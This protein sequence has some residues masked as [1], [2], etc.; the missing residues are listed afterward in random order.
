MLEKIRYFL[1]GARD[2]WRA[3]QSGPIQDELRRLKQEA[4][5]RGEQ[6]T[7]KRIWCLEQ[8]LKAQDEFTDAFKQMKAGAYYDGWCALER[9]EL[10]LHFLSPHLVEED[11]EYGL[12]FINRHIIQYQ[13]LFPYRHFLSPEIL[14]LEKVCT[15][16]N[17]PVAIRCSCGHRVGEIYDGEMC[18]RIVTK[19][20]F[21]GVAVVT[22]PLQKY[23]V[24]F[25]CDSN[26]GE[27]KDFYDYSLV[28]YVVE[29]LVSPFHDWTISRETRRQP[30]S[31]FAYTGRNDK[32]PCESGRKYKKCCLRHEGVLRPHFEFTFSVPPP[33]D[34]M[35]VEYSA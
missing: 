3:R 17:K 23:S 28:R 14:E 2:N 8:A 32:C 7:A 27:K 6:T 19:C 33:P 11:R 21:L 20:E 15:I 31:W 9:A 13:S 24:P 5:R 1:S 26:T 34:L 4:V 29:R 10:A 16:C 25:A 18:G 35:R 30:H 12:D 22:E